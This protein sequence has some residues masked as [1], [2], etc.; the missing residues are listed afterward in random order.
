MNWMR[1]A[2]LPRFRKL[3]GIIDADL[4]EGDVVQVTVVNRYN[5]YK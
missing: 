3:W 2:A 4:K 1:I 5:T